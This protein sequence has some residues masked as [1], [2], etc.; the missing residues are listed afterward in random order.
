M[1][2]AFSSNFD[3][4]VLWMDLKRRS[5]TEIPIFFRFWLR[6]SKCR[7]ISSRTGPFYL[8]N[9]RGAGIQ[10]SDTATSALRQ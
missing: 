4:Y 5:F 9:Q 3:A 10:P 1:T 6:E 8:K 7:Q 2:R